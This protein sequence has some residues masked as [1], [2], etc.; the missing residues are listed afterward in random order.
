MA[1]GIVTRSRI[2]AHSSNSGAFHLRD[3][4]TRNTIESR[5]DAGRISDRFAPLAGLG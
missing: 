1:N 5:H 2:K 4:S 3:Q